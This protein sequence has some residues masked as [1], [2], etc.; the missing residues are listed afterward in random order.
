MKM[1]SLEKTSFIIKYDICEQIKITEKSFLLE[2]IKI[3]PNKNINL[4]SSVYLGL[5]HYGIIIDD[6]NGFYHS[7]FVG[8]SN[9]YDRL[10]NTCAFMLYQFDEPSGKISDLSSNDEIIFYNISMRDDILK[11]YMSTLDDFGTLES[12]QNF[13]QLLYGKIKNLVI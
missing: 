10:Q 11:I 5:G 13:F 6:G 4:I 12:F 3:H 1:V 8:G 7:L 9:Y 2:S